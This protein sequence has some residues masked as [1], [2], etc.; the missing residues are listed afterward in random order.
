MR[1][2]LITGGSGFF[3]RAF[4]NRLLASDA[5]PDR[6]CIY[7]RD[8][9]KQSRMAAELGHDERLRFF[10]GD[11]RD[12]DRLRRAMS[13]V[14]VVVHAA[15]LKRIEAAHWN[16]DEVVKT[17]VL[18]SMNV[19]DAAHDARVGRVVFLSTDKAY[20]PVSPYGQTK[21]LAESLFM[22]A[23]RTHA[24]GPRYSCT[25]YGNVTG[26]TGSVIPVWRNCIATGDRVRMTDP[27]AT[28][29]W[30]W[31]HEA[32]DLV[33]DTIRRMPDTIAVPVLP[34]YR[35]GD[36]AE[37]MDIK[38]PEIVGLPGWEKKFE[39]MSA[40]LHSNE[41]RRMSVDELREALKNV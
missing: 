1:S 16:P 8:E 12:K 32:C 40:D 17:N 22:A 23:N 14:E 9:V 31:D 41:A 15:A 19:I 37:A 2:I 39:S 26:S 25:R 33:L 27:E 4:V 34:A 24:H 11:V 3:G 18:G 36:L 21:A 28:R 38:D 5:G 29:F 13:G 7:S 20:Q 6:I 35:L 30:M 10:I